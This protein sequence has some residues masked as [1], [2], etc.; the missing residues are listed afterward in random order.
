MECQLAKYTTIIAQTILS[1][2]VEMSKHPFGNYVVQHVLGYASSQECSNAIE[3]LTPHVHNLS[4]H[5]SAS[6]VVEKCLLHCKPVEQKGIFHV[7]LGSLKDKADSLDFHNRSC[8]PWQDIIVNQYGNYVMQ[9]A[10][11]VLK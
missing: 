10:I 4:K 1:N 2:I 3:L 5:K 7:L 6:N 9:R 11:K 8:P